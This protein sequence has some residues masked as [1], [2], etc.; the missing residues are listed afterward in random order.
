MTKIPWKWSAVLGCVLAGMLS[1]GVTSNALAARPTGTI[2]A[3]PSARGPVLQLL[4]RDYQIE[5]LA[6]L[7]A[8]FTF[9]PVIIGPAALDNPATMATVVRAY[10]AG[11]PVAIVQATQ[12]Q[13]NEF[14]GL[15]EDDPVA[16]CEPAEGSSRIALYG[17]RHVLR[18]PAE[19]SRY[20]L[21]FVAGYAGP[22]RKMDR[23]WLDERFASTPPPLPETTSLS[24]SPNLDDL[25]AKVHCSELETGFRGS[26]QQDIYLTALRSFGQEQDYVLVNSYPKFHP[27]LSTGVSQYAV[28]MS[29]VSPADRPLDDMP[30]QRIV[31][32]E[33]STTTEY[34]SRYTNSKS[35]TLKYGGGFT[36]FTVGTQ[37]YFNVEASNSITIGKETTVSVPPVSILNT[38]TLAGGGA[39]WLFSPANPQSGVLYSFATSHLVR[40]PQSAYESA[41]F[42]DGVPTGELVLS[43]YANGPSLVN[44]LCGFHP[45]FPTWTIT[46]PE[47]TA[48]DPE[49]VKRGGGTFTIVGSRMYPGIVSHVLLAGDALPSSNVVPLDDSHIEVVVPSGV[50]NGKG[51]SVQV[52]T[53]FNGSTLPSNTMKVNI[54]P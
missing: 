47:I 48:I 38:T 52:N 44:G 6:R 7:P 45:P 19:D 24:D 31:F 11:Q 26:T 16:S 43:F 9:A 30:G 36:G 3:D 4:S 33:P 39:S 18:Q 27:G 2:Y 29:G 13:T 8:S 51:K 22:G 21:P 41:G 54:E 14:D 17:L 53:F 42:D 1:I 50:K 37:A 40:I 49:S 25:A 28:G 23:Q 5:D 46:N 12:A 20:C 32:S 34:V 35:E 10:Q 15:V